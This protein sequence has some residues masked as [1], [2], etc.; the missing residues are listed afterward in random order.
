MH[1]YQLDIVVCRQCGAVSATNA[2]RTHS[3]PPSPAARICPI[4]LPNKEYQFPPPASDFP[5]LSNDDED[6]T[7]PPHVWF[8]TVTPFIDELDDQHEAV[9]GWFSLLAPHGLLAVRLWRNAG[10]LC[11]LLY[12]KS[13]PRMARAREALQ[14]A[15][16]VPQDLEL[17]SAR[18]NLLNTT[19]I[20]HLGYMDVIYADPELVPY[21]RSLALAAPGCWSV[22]WHFRERERQNGPVKDESLFL[23]YRNSMNIQK[24]RQL[25]MGLEVLDIFTGRFAVAHDAYVEKSLQPRRCYE[26]TSCFD[27]VV[28]DLET[29]GLYVKKSGVSTMHIPGVWVHDYLRLGHADTIGMEKLDLLRMVAVMKTIEQADCDR[30]V[31]VPLVPTSGP[32]YRVLCAMARRYA[33]DHPHEVEEERRPL[34]EAFGWNRKR[35]HFR[36]LL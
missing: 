34:S 31:M 19:S 20:L 2:P 14:H 9:W 28:G 12:F 5:V 11:W 4:S 21:R 13:A 26:Q 10:L 18:K 17:S 8:H 1:I 7:V 29:Y 32:H 16:R 3:L 6:P 22:A 30:L 25:N 24:T 33:A 27:D 35:W 15:G 23:L 36:I